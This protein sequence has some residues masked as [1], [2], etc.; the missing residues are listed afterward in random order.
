[1]LDDLIDQIVCTKKGA[2]TPA[3]VVKSRELS[4]HT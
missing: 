4:F 1:V 3:D 2:P